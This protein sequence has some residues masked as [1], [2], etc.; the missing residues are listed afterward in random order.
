MFLLK[1]IRN[2]E[3]LSVFWGVFTGDTAKSRLNRSNMSFLGVFDFDPK[4]RPFFDHI[5]YKVNALY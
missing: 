3:D 2:P 5:D 1:N 4:M